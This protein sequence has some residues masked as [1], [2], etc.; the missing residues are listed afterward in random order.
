VKT[1]WIDVSL[2]LKTDVMHWP[3]DPPVLIERVRDMNAGDTV[4]LTKIT[5]G[6]HSGTH[7]DAPR[8]FIKSGKGADRI[9][10]DALIGPARVIG[11]SARNAIRKEDLARHRIK[12]GERILLRTRNSTKKIFYKDAFTEDFVYLDKTAAEFL[13]ERGIRTIGVDYLSVGGYKKD[14]HDVHKTLLG[15]GIL[16]I[17]GLDL[18]P[19]LPG[20]YD[21]ICLPVKILDSDGAPARVVVKAR[22]VFRNRK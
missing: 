11:I 18:S 4:N 13:V 6:A 2:T 12:K 19:I 15:A 7:I 21:M 22:K 1:D 10:L 5:M 8:H 3:G 16:V 17:E 20:R 14:G 9:S